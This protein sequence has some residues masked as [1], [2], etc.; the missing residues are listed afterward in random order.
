LISVMEGLTRSIDELVETSSPSESLVIRLK[1][2]KVSK[3]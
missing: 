2:T 1:Y 3:W